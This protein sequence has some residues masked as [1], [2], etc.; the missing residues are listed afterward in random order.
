M[1]KY[2][3]MNRKLLTPYIHGDKEEVGIVKVQWEMKHH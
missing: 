2:V 3:K 1:I